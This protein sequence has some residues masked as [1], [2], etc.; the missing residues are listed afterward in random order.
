VWFELG[1]GQKLSRVR[2]LEAAATGAEIVATACPFCMTM[3]EE[4]ASAESGAERP[5]VRDLAE[6]IADAG[7]PGAGTGVAQP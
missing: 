7:G 4:I 2:Y 1:L 6:I 3:F 5:A